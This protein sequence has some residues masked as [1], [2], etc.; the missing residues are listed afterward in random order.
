LSASVFVSEGEA[1]IRQKSLGATDEFVV[2]K[3][4]FAPLLIAGL[5]AEQDIL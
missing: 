4:P 3:S 2:G 5:E 1:G